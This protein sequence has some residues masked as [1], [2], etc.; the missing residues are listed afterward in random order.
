MRYVGQKD[1]EDH[2]PN[3]IQVTD[4]GAG[5]RP[6][7]PEPIRI[8][9]VQ[10]TTCSRCGARGHAAREC[11]AGTGV[12]YELVEEPLDEHLP[13][14]DEGASAK[15]SEMEKELRRRLKKRPPSSSSS[16]SSSSLPSSVIR[17]YMKKRKA[18]KELKV[19]AGLAGATD[20]KSKKKRKRQN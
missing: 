1:G 5:R 7:A 3:N 11:F 18:K 9:A 4:A 17:E 14:R 19:L 12:Q 8:G 20:I 6:G 13:I 15:A 16:S 10:A 2:D